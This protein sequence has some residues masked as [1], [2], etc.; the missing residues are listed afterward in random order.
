MEGTSLQSTAGVGGLPLPAWS[1]RPPCHAGTDE[2]QFLSRR[3][4]RRASVAVDAFLCP[5]P[6]EMS[7]RM[8]STRYSPGSYPADNDKES[9][10]HRDS[11]LLEVA[12]SE[13]PF[14]VHACSFG[15]VGRA[16]RKTPGK[17]ST[18]C[19][20]DGRQI[21]PSPPPPSVKLDD[22]LSKPRCH[23]PGETHG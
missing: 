10:N 20:C 5:D 22:L 18:S 9:M 15:S 19:T 6:S 16:P 2:V 13:V 1:D 8:T 21:S 23:R 11:P 14:N 3:K 4:G 7:F 17:R 12:V